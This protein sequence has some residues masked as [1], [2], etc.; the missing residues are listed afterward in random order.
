MQPLLQALAEALPNAR[1]VG[2]GAAQPSTASTASP[3][4][5]G[6]TLAASGDDIDVAV[7]AGGLTEP[8]IERR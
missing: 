4:T 6:D 3:N 7:P 5:S 8:P 1:L 2:Q